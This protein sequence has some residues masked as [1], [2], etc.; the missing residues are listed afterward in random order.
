MIGKYSIKGAGFDVLKTKLFKVDIPT[1]DLKDRTSY[2]GTPVYSNLE[3]KPF[4]YE[5]LEGEQISILNGI[6]I[7]ILSS[8]MI[9]QA[10]T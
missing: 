1:P 8:V 7:V 10:G 6:T 4:N 2:L 5:T 3:I 9:Q